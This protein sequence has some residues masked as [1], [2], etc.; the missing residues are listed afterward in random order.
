M[1][2]M[3]TLLTDTVESVMVAGGI[4]VDDLEAYAAIQDAAM[5]VPCCAECAS[6]EAERAPGET[7]G[8]T[9]DVAHAYVWVWDQVTARSVERWRTGVA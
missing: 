3:G 8:V 9:F 2:A 1:S 4:P 5:G 7:F 6:A